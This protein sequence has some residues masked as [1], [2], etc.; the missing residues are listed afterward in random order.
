[1]FYLGLL[2]FC[3]LFGRCLDYT[4]NHFI[5]NTC[6]MGMLIIWLVIVCTIEYPVTWFQKQQRAS[7]ILGILT[8]DAIYA[9]TLIFGSL[10]SQPPMS[11]SRAILLLKTIAVSCIFLTLTLLTVLCFSR[12]VDRDGLVI[13]NGLVYHPGK[14]YWAPWFLKNKLEFFNFNQSLWS[15]VN[16]TNYDKVLHGQVTIAIPSTTRKLDTKALLKRASGEFTYLVAPLFA[17]LPFKQAAHYLSDLKGTQLNLGDGI[18]ATI[19]TV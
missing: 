6:T 4:S 16:L 18:T 10:S 7:I 14:K 9:T 2:G 11:I 5:Y 1:M 15:T 17:T 12:V 19:Q 3:I 8:I 13:L